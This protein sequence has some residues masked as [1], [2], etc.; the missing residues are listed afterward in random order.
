[1]VH[2]MRDVKQRFSEQLAE[3]F[4]SMMEEKKSLQELM[5]QGYLSSFGFLNDEIF[6]EKV[7]SQQ[8]LPSYRNYLFVITPKL[9]SEFHD[10]YKKAKKNYQNIVELNNDKQNYLASLQ[11]KTQN[12]QDGVR[13][14][15][16]LNRAIVDNY[17]GKE[18]VFGAEI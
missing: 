9:N 11:A 12:L 14:E 6:F 17:E 4:Q 16:E 7:S 1:M 10:E 13:R 2:Y 5:L 8:K 15:I 3:N 18:V